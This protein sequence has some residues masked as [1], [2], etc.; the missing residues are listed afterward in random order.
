MSDSQGRVLYGKAVK[1]C[2]VI[3]IKHLIL[4][5]KLM[6]VWEAFRLIYE[7]SCVTVQLMLDLNFIS[8]YRDGIW[9]RCN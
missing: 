1:C 9:L 2:E 5:F 4:F 6:K 8:N 7:D 3:N